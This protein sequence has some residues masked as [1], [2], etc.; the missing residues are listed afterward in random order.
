MSE[1]LLRLRRIVPVPASFEAAVGRLNLAPSA[2][3]AA[4]RERPAPTGGWRLVSSARAIG[5]MNTWIRAGIVRVGRVHPEDLP[6]DG[7]LHVRTQAGVFAVPVVADATPG[8]RVLLVPW[9][10]DA[11]SGGINAN[12]LVKA[13][14]REPF[15]GQPCLNGTALDVVPG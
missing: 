10:D 8:R 12:Q 9:G 3:I 13:T 2:L 1:W 4:L 6:V 14:T 7:V 5:G 15:T 11:A